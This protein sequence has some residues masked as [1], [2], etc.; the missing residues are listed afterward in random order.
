[1]IRRG[2]ILKTFEQKIAEHTIPEPN[3][4]CLLWIGASDTRGYGQMNIGGKTRTVTQLVL[5]HAGKPRPNKRHGALHSCDVSCCVEERH[6]RWG[7]QTDNMQDAARRGRVNRAGLEVGHGK[8]RAVGNANR[9]KA[10]AVCGK[11][12]RAK[13]NLVKTCGR[14]CFIKLMRHINGSRGIPRARAA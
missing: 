14:A 12:F 10:C 1:M 9:N 11:G 5:E 6:L 2:T 4:G 13:H 7:L 8:M 3:S